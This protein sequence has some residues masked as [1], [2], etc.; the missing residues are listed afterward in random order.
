MHPVEPNAE[1]YADVFRALLGT[2]DESEREAWEARWEAARR[3]ERKRRDFDRQ[4]DRSLASVT[5][6][7]Q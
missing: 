5:W 6:G 1:S 4:W 7:G 2:L 3:V